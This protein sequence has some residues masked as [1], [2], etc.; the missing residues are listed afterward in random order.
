M[1]NVILLIAI[2]FLSNSCVAQWR[3]IADFIGTDGSLFTGGEYITCV[4]FLDLP[5]P[6]RIGF[7]GTESEMHKTTDGGITWSSVWGN[8]GSFE[9]YYITDICFKDSLVG[10][11]SIVNTG[12]ITGDECYRTTDGGET[13]NE[14]DVPG[15]YYSEGEGVYYSVASDRLFLISDTLIRISTDLGDTWSDSLPYYAISSF[16]FSSPLNGILPVDFYPDTTEGFIITSDGGVSWDTIHSQ[17]VGGEVLAIAGTSTCFIT[18]GGWDNLILRSDD[19]GHTWRQVADVQDSLQYCTGIIRGDFSRLYIQTDSGMYVSIDSGVTWKNDSGPP[20]D[21]IF[22]QDRFYSAKGVTI[23]GMTHGQSGGALYD[24][25]LWEEEWPQAGVAEAVP[26]SIINYVT[27]SPNPTGESTIIT[28]GLNQEAYVKIN[29]FDILGNPVSGGRV[30]G[31]GG[32]GFEGLFE[33]GN[34]E[35]PLSLQGLPSGTYFARILTAYGNV[36]TVKLVKE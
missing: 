24:G 3:E 10:W 18:S 19:F 31:S 15:V 29:L 32:E 13:W 28:F 20:Y 34:H 26:D 5:G 8:G 25:G 16:S 1:R 30:P 9:G 22:T 12:G 2:M 6:P 35:V 11:F 23:A 4:Y 33:P 27:S 14:L 21:D 17:N 36:A 7:V